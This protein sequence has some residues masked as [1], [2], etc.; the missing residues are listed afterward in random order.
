[1]TTL[2]LVLVSGLLTMVACSVSVTTDHDKNVDFS[3][4]QTWAWAPEVGSVSEDARLANRNA[5]QAVRDAIELEFVGKGYV[6]LDPDV[7]Q[8]LVLYHLSLTERIEISDIDRYYGLNNPYFG[9]Q[10]QGSSPV[11]TSYDEGTLIIDLIERETKKPVWRGIGRK[12]IVSL[13]KTEEARRNIRSAVADIMKEYP[14]K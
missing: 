7:S 4:F 11:A 10:M 6:M 14:P 13:S 1:M 3:R 12:Q 2:R 5:D 8:L 9:W